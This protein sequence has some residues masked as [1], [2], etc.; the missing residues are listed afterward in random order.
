MI[1][2]HYWLSQEKKLAELAPA[3]SAFSGGGATEVIAAVDF[4]PL[5]G[6]FTGS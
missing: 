6:G 1:F 2:F 4:Y 5:I 3:G